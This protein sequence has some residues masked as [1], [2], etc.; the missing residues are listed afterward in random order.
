[1]PAIAPATEAGEDFEETFRQP[2]GG[3]FGDIEFVSLL[4]DI[5]FQGTVILHFTNSF[6]SFD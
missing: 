3:L 4:M 1:M 5:F 6:N 2:I